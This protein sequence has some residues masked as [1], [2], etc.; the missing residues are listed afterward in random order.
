M[1]KILMLF[2]ISLFL[3]SCTNR[4]VENV[5]DGWWTIDTIYY[6]NY[7]IKTCLANNSLFFK[8]DNKSE[9]PVAMSNCGPIIKNSFDRS[10]E[11]KL[12]NSE[13]ANDSIPL[14]L[15]IVTKNEIFAGLNKIVFY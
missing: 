3:Y 9:L 6:K 5:I 10:A 11:I 7:N 1:R 14:R 2:L 12:T 15:K 13:T 8:F 4:K